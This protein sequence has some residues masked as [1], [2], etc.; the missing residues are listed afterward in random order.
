MLVVIIS[1]IINR[2][3]MWCLLPKNKI[4]FLCCTE[5]FLTDFNTLKCFS[6][7]DGHRV[8]EPLPAVLTGCTSDNHQ[9]IAGPE[10]Q[11]TIHI[12]T[13]TYGLCRVAHLSNMHV[14][15][16]QEVGL[17][18]KLHNERPQVRESNLLCLAVR[19]Q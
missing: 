5:L 12:C 19:A 3:N 16:W 7:S 17:L 8:L 4:T 13:H 18:C 11:T 2:E 10:R 1:I 14:L 9:F 15:L 6:C